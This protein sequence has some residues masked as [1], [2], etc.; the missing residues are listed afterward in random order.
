MAT[1]SGKTLVMAMAIAWHILNRL[2][3]PQDPRFSKHGATVEP[4]GL[5]PRRP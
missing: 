4:D 1:G 3:N 2:A 5:C